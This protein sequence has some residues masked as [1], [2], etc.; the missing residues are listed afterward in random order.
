MHCIRNIIGIFADNLLHMLC[1]V[2]A[3]W[4][5]KVHD[6]IDVNALVA[7]IKPLKN[8]S[9]SFVRDTFETVR[10]VNKALTPALTHGHRKDFFQRVPKVMKFHFSF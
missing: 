5:L 9:S 10:D 8:V 2:F 6:D 3:F 7:E 1:L 4:Y